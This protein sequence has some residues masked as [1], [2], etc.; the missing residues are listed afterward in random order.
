MTIE[1]WLIIVLLL[2]IASDLFAIWKR[3]NHKDSLEWQMEL[4]KDDYA[5]LDVELFKV[6]ERIGALEQWYE[7]CSLGFR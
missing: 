6:N 4:L 3:E 7:R 5:K 1:I 2:N